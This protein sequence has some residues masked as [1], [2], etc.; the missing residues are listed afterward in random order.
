MLKKN[1][2]I[3]LKNGIN[4]KISALQGIFVNELL[5][6][7]SYDK[8]DEFIACRV[9]NEVVSLI[10]R[11]KVDS[12]IEFLTIK[13]PAGMEV[14]RRTFCF[15]L[16]KVALKLFPDRKLVI[17]HSLGPGYYFDLHGT[18]L[19]KED[20][21]LLEKE[22]KKEV[23][24]DLPILRQKIK[25][26]EAL[27][28]FKKNNREDKYKLLSSLNM[29]KLAI[30]CC[31]DFFQIFD[32]P[33]ASRTGVLKL[34]KLIY[35]PP[36]FIL[37]FPQRSNVNEV[38]PFI[39]QKNIFRVYQEYK[40]WGKV[41]NV[42]NVGLLNEI[43]IKDEMPN[44][45]QVE[46][47][48]HA[49][50][51]LQIAESIYK[52]RDRV[53]VVAI[54][55]PSS[56][57]KTTFSKRLSIQLMALGLKPVAISVDNY[58]VNRNETPVDENGKPDYETIDAINFK[59]FNSNLKDLMEGKE[60]KLPVYNFFTGVSALNGN[61]L[62]INKDEIIIIEGIHCLNERLTF[63]VPK[64]NKIKIYISVLTQMNIDNNNRIPTTDS[65]IIRRIV[66]DNKYRGNSALKTLQTWPSVRRGEET[67]IFPFQNDADEYFNS[68]LDYE[69]A[70]LRSYAEPLLMQ[71]KPFHEEYDET[72]RLLKFLS[73]FLMINEKNVPA[74]SLIRE[75]I[76]RI[77]FQLLIYS[78]VEI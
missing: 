12:A 56:S 44:F 51:I 63:L 1:I 11:L 48:L 59:L 24:E 30:Y 10:F 34:F 39:E 69:L 16:E 2:E 19:K 21:E 26:E 58:F 5:Q 27:D 46:E 14:Y 71:I 49:K 50:K 36:G 23:E 62:K 43:I 73:Y 7:F 13:D 70:I 66:R 35:Y 38:A 40:A 52:N 61:S 8:K 33:L 77:I 75:F 32:L 41:L 42:N 57:G 60:V 37:Q 17:G 54:A 76:R 45:I 47:A 9:N 29:S 3:F 18:E 4:I 74:T 65:R 64:E 25:Y 67:Y 72:I 68:A 15:L 6:Y 28:Y 22:M 20:V 31:E 55:G 53:K 78:G